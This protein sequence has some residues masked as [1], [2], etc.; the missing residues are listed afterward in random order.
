[1]QFKELSTGTGTFIIK[2][3]PGYF[4]G[5]QVNVSA[6]AVTL[7]IFDGVSS[8][9]PAVAIAGG[10][11]AFPL[12]AVGTTPNYIYDCHFSQGLTIIVGGSGT[13]SMTVTYY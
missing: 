13:L 9:A 8:S 10:A 7:Q 12:S 5:I 4:Q 11:A 3:G 1:M 6:A 2:T